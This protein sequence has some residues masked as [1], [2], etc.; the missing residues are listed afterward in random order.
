MVVVYVPV[1]TTVVVWSECP[2]WAQVGKAPARSSKDAKNSF[3][4]DVV[5]EMSI[6]L[7]GSVCGGCVREWE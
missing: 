4:V 5:D 6:E 2:S 1:E 3:I 7:V